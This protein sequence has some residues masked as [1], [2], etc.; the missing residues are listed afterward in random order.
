MGEGSIP[1]IA[2]LIIKRS[3]EISE[4]G[5]YIVDYGAEAVYAGFACGPEKIPHELIKYS[6]AIKIASYTNDYIDLMGVRFLTEMDNHRSLKTM[7]RIARLFLVR[8]LIRIGIDLVV[9]AYLQ[10]PDSSEEHD[11]LIDGRML[12]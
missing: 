11:L 7:I 6:C 9:D 1:D 3:Y 12:P 8:W 5:S 4:Y 10:E 2:K